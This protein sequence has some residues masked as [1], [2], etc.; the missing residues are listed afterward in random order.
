MVSIG[1]W[2]AWFWGRF[3]GPAGWP[4]ASSEIFATPTPTFFYR[5]A[6]FGSQGKH[7]SVYTEKDTAEG[8]SSSCRGVTPIPTPC[9]PSEM[10][11]SRRSGIDFF[12]T[13][14]QSMAAMMALA[15]GCS[16][17]YSRS[18]WYWLAYISANPSLTRHLKNLSNPAPYGFKKI[19]LALQKLFLPY[20]I[21][22]LIPP[23]V[24]EISRAV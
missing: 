13:G 2:S 6:R 16:R 17:A 14:P 9:L 15:S 20:T 4:P 11:S 22:F 23:G 12:R 1:V 8:I 7:V 5:G 3:R 24:A 19:V 10:A 18:Q 21:N